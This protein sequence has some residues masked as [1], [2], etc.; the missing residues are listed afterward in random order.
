MSGNIKVGWGCADITPRGGPVSLFGQWETRVS[1]VIHDPL[2]ANAMVIQSD[3]CRTIWVACDLALISKALS[4]EV[5]R[6]LR[7]SLPGFREDELVLSATH[8]HTGPSTDQDWFTALLDGQPDPPGA[9]PTAECCRQAAA[10]IERAVLQAAAAPELSRFE[11]ALSHTITGVSRRA[12]Y[13][14]GS[15]AMY[16]DLHRPDFAGM[17]GRDG[18]PMQIIYVRRASDCRLTGIVAAVPCTA[19]ADEMAGY[20]TADYWHTAR[21]GIREELGEDVTVLGLIRS[22][23]DQS[24]HTM[25]DR[26]KHVGRLQGEAGAVEMGARVGKAIIRAVDDVIVTIEPD[27]AHGHLCA[28]EPMPI[29][30][31]TKEE[32][33]AAKKYI[34]DGGAGALGPLNEMMAYSA[35]A[36]R[37]RRYEGD[38]ARY[39]VNIHAVRIGDVVF[40][41]NPFEM[42]IEYADRIRMA[43]PEAFVIDVQLAGDEELGYL[44]TQRAIDGGG[45]STMIFSCALDAKG[46]DM[47]VDKSIRLIKSTFACEE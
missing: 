14:D 25:V 2:T 31:V 21:E 41:T 13:R 22:A 37:I 42:Y 24:P 38:I 46:G 17:E 26:A 34:A 19:Q 28:R 30:G 9:I 16:G 47:V 11:V 4:A 18:G 35:A 39:P 44:S 12:T 32:Y 5:K 15:A 10:G 36:T 1:D 45:Y 40:I 33:E 27:A 3:G 6:L 43:C 8:V 20:V 23:G 7:A 29:W